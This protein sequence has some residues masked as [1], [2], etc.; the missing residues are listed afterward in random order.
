MTRR[1]A[2]LFQM[3]PTGILPLQQRLEHG[4]WNSPSMPGGVRR[5]DL[6]RGS[7]QHLGGIDGE[8]VACGGIADDEVVSCELLQLCAPVPTHRAGPIR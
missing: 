7:T 5:R 3:L 8:H 4:R 2:G 1:V 6:R